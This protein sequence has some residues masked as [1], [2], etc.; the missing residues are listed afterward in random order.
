[1]IC[2]LGLKI[3]GG[4]TSPLL[5]AFAKFTAYLMKGGESDERKHC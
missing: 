2:I 4:R 5:F 1:M 3:G